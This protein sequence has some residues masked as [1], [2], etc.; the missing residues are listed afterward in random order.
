M[1]PNLCQ[2]VA[3]NELIQ[4][5]PNFNYEKLYLICGDVGPFEAGIPLEV[6]L[7]MAIR[8]KK[9]HKCRILAPEWFNVES[10]RKFID[11]ETREKGGLTPVPRYFREF[12]NLLLLDAKDDIIDA[13]QVAFAPIFG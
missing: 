4:I 9:Q 10:L 8:L 13:D 12:S 2:F 11:A 7:W 6:P 3:E 5:I 1:D